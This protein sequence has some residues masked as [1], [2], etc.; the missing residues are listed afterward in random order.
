MFDTNPHVERLVLS[1]FAVQ[2]KR[3]TERLLDTRAEILT[4]KVAAIPS[5]P[6]IARTCPEVCRP[7]WIALRLVRDRSYTVIVDADIAS[8]Q[9]SFKFGDR[10]TVDTCC[11]PCIQKQGP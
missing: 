6:Q 3:I 1:R 8:L 2:I 9:S 5:N 11:K 4:G 7:Q 10:L